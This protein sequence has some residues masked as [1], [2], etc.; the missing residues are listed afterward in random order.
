MRNILIHEYYDVDF[1]IVWD[2][3]TMNLSELKVV[4]EKM[5]S[6]L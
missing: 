1:A 5:M 6:E 3:A 2:T 4:I